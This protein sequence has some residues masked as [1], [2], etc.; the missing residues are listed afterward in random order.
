V[1]KDRMNEA[2]EAVLL[3]ARIRRA[4]ETSPR[5]TIPE[6]FAARVAS[7][8]PPLPQVVLTPQRYG[9]RAAA[10]SLAALMALMLAFAHRA[11]GSSLYWLS[12]E[13]IFCLQFVLLAVW[14]VARN[15]GYTLPRLF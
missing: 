7:Q 14:I 5:T 15:A 13:W 8:V 4:L 3:E 6:G 1:A 2:A 10:V 11:T 12:L 9:Q